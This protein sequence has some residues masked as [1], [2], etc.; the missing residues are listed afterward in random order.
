MRT[1]ERYLDQLDGL[2]ELYDLLRVIEHTRDQQ[3]A[4]ARD[5]NRL[6]DE[7][8]LALYECYRMF[9]CNDGVTVADFE[10]FLPLYFNHRVANVLGPKH[11]P[12][13][14]VV[15]NRQTSKPVCGPEAA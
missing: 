6:L 2:P 12:L 3:Q 13:R 14:L 11:G 9:R 10:R 7:R 4:A 8:D 15:N 5:L 1:F